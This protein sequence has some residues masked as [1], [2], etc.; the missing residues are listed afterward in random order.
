MDGLSLWCWYWRAEFVS[1][2]KHVG[3]KRLLIKAADG[4][5]P[6]PQYG[7]A[8]AACRAAGIEPVPWAYSYGEPGE[9]EV[10]AATGEKTIVFDPEIEYE[11]LSAPAQHAFIADV[12]AV[13]ARGIRTW[14]ATWARPEAHRSYLFQELGMAL[15]GWLPMV[16]WQVWHPRDPA[17]WL[18]HWRAQGLGNTVPWLP[19]SEVSADELAGSV[20]AALERFG[21]ATIWSARLLT[22]AMVSALADLAPRP[23]PTIDEAAARAA[24]DGIAAYLAEADRAIDEAWQRAVALKRAVGLE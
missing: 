23:Q 20:R 14:A 4:T 3:A 5:D 12:G 10:L 24:L 19:A 22:P 21:G 2:A 17:Y 18:D 7:P 13:R 6:W 15:D 8:A 9:A 11:Q 16:A 1:L